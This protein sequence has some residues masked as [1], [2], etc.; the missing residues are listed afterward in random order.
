MIDSIDLFPFFRAFFSIDDTWDTL[1]DR[2]KTMHNFMLLQFLSIKHPEYIQEFNKNTID[3]NV[4]VLNALHNAFKT[5]KYPGWMFT[6]V[7]KISKVDDTLSKYPVELINE[8]IKSH[9]LEEKSF[10]FLYETHKEEVL[11]ELNIQ[12]KSWNQTI[13]PTKK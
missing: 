7:D 8:F 4:H 10:T 2:A 9:Q 12:L 11:Q 5:P 3:L 13:K 6:K 1:T